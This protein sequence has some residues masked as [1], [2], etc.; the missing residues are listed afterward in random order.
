MKLRPLHDYLVVELEPV[1]EFTRGG[2]I[3]VAP[4]PVRVG[5]VTAIGKGRHYPGLDGVKGKYVPTVLQVGERIA[6]FQAVTQTKQGRQLDMS[7]PD[8]HELLR[9]TDAL[10]VIEEGADV[11]VTPA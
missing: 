11:E 6:F 5:K 7:L 10:F 4:E 8:N 1:K 3:K 9:E 2:I